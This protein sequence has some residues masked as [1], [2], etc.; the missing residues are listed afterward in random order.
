LKLSK[1]Y[2]IQ[3][4]GELDHTYLLEQYSKLEE[5]DWNYDITRQHTFKSVHGY[6]KWI[7][8]IYEDVSSPFRA[9]GIDSVKYVEQFLTN[10]LGSVSIR[11]A[12]YTKLEPFKEIPI[13]KDSGVFLEQHTRVHI[14]IISN[15]NTMFGAFHPDEVD[16]NNNISKE[17]WIKWIHMEPGKAYALN[18]CEAPHAVSNK[19]DQ[20]RVHLI[21]DFTFLNKGKRSVI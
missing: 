12:I 10:V 15:P 2:S 5:N 16:N 21:C 4:L 6:T 9:I 7:P 18:N 20:A 3:Y 11:R 13:H 8:I 17:E 19:S 1:N 14:P